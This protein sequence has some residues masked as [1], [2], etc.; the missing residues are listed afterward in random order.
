MDV[1]V[2]KNMQKRNLDCYLK[3]SVL[4]QNEKAEEIALWHK[5]VF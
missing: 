2:N 3:K 5:K 1:N 4:K